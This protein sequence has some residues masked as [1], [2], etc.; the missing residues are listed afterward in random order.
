MNTNICVWGA[1]GGHGCTT[2]AALTAATLAR[3]GTVTLND[4][5]RNEG[6]YPYTGQDGLVVLGEGPPTADVWDCGPLTP[7]SSYEALPGQVN[8]VVLRGP[9]YAGMAALMRHNP[10][11]DHLVVITEP[12]RALD[13]TD[14][15]TVF[16]WETIEFPYDPAVARRGDAGTLLITRKGD[17]RLARL[18]ARTRE[19][20]TA[21]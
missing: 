18:A 10:P 21:T 6:F 16:G 19:N 9:D 13:V 3:D 11:V 14:T 2:V 12:G 20:R 17:S 5:A 1:R 8:V 4:L 15:R 7:D